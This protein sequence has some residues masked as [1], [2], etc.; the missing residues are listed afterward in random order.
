MTEHTKEPWR[1]DPA[2]K[3]DNWRIIGANGQVVSTFS[4]NMDME[5][6]RRIVE[7][8]NYCKGLPT[9][10]I[11]TAT[12]LGKT[13]EVSLHQL[14][15]VIAQRDQLLAAL[16]AVRNAGD[17]YTSAIELNMDIDGNELLAVVDKAI[18]AVKGD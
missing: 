16:E 4:G 3:K 1:I 17:W 7:C 8:V 18:A 2:T 11:A 5:N 13:A 9:E 14:A 6:A 12:A 15:D 10:G